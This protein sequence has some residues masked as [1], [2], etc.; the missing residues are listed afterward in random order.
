MLDDLIR[1]EAAL[2]AQLAAVR[3]QIRATKAGITVQPGD[4]VRLPNG[5][6]YSVCLVAL[7][8]WSGSG[9]PNVSGQRLFDSGMVGQVVHPLGKK[10][11]K[12]EKE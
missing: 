4:V 9:K 7:D 12:E 5:H 11:E 1:Q 10:W 3:S 8:N 6:R 2:K